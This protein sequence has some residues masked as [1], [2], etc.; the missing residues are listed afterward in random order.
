MSVIPKVQ[1]RTVVKMRNV[2]RVCFALAIVVI[3]GLATKIQL[4]EKE[5]GQIRAAFPVPT[6]RSVPGSSTSPVAEAPAG[7]GVG[8]LRIAQESGHI[9]PRNPDSQIYHWETAEG[10][11]VNEAPK[12]YT[13][14]RIYLAYYGPEGVQVGDD[15]VF[16]SSVGPFS[17]ARFSQKIRS[18][19]IVTR[20]AVTK[21]VAQ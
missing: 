11:L 12:A 17:Q 9:D 13:A 6:A 18:H 5:L 1:E 15:V 7:M 10:V 19:Y 2:R 4:L 21:I 8:D 20:F 3:A 14:V 16:I